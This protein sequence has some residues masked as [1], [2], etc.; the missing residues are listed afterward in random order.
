MIAIFFFRCNLNGEVQHRTRVLLE[1][2]PHQWWTQQPDQPHLSPRKTTAAYAR[3]DDDDGARDYGIH[4]S[5]YIEKGFV[6]N[7]QK[8]VDQYQILVM[9]NNVGFILSKSLFLCLVGSPAQGRSV[10]MVLRPSTNSKIPEA[11]T[12]GRDLNVVVGF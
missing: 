2:D 7:I 4:P 8:I 12:G 10:Q 9:G 6:Q 11:L 5:T 3:K 1:E